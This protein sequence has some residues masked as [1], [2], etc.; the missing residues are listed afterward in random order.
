M[1]CPLPDCLF[2]GWGS[3]LTD[4]QRITCKMEIDDCLI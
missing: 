4:Q 3:L 2:G 1:F